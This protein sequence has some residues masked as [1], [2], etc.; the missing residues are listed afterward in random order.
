MNDILPSDKTLRN[1]SSL[2]KSQI[3]KPHSPFPK[4]DISIRTPI[5]GQ[6]RFLSNSP[7]ISDVA[8]SSSNPN[9]DNNLK[10]AKYNLQKNQIQSKEQFNYYSLP[11]SSQ[12]T[13]KKGIRFDGYGKQEPNLLSDIY[14]Q[15]IKNI[16]YAKNHQ[17]TSVIQPGSNQKEGGA[18]KQSN[19]SS[20]QPGRSKIEQLI[21][22]HAQTFSPNNEG[23]EDTNITSSENLKKTLPLSE[24]RGEI[25]QIKNVIQ[26]M[27]F[28]VKNSGKLAQSAFEVENLQKVINTLES[29]G[30]KLS[31]KELQN[32]RST[33]ESL[34]KNASKASLTHSDNPPK[35]RLLLIFYLYVLKL[36]QTYDNQKRTS[37]LEIYMDDLTN[38]D[39]PGLI[40]LSQTLKPYSHLSMTDWD[41]I[42]SLVKGDNK[43]DSGKSKIPPPPGQ[44][45]VSTRRQTRKKKS[46]PDA[47]PLETLQESKEEDETEGGGLLKQFK[48]WKK[49]TKKKEKSDQKK[50]LPTGKQSKKNFKEMDK[51]LDKPQKKGGKKKLL[52][53]DLQ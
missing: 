2:D 3:I 20:L 31:K 45:G 35:V 36:L 12:V 52:S 43:G 26:Q 48:K 7:Y 38:T 19:I 33:I 29:V 6:Y 28:A 1:W 49:N 47:K 34:F 21:L 27:N 30:E 41:K 53:H 24:N 15:Q 10:Q 18:K 16:N 9:F 37:A 42:D 11:Q 22:S 44:S 23:N 50:G 14:N 39:L 25:N 51:I 46:Q 32:L 13:P 5:K 8:H 4:N 40:S 17:T